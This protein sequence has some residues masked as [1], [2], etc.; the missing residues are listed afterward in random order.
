LA[1]L[2]LLPTLATATISRKYIPQ[3]LVDLGLFA[4]FFGICP[5][6]ELLQ[7]NRTYANCKNGALNRDFS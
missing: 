2:A 1:R 4:A 7:A 3:T 6:P 5:P